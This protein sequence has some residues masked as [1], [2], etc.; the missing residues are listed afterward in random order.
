MSALMGPTLELVVTGRVGDPVL[1]FWVFVLLVVLALRRWR[2]PLRAPGAVVGVH[3]TPAAI[4][5]WC[6]QRKGIDSKLEVLV[7]GGVALHRVTVDA[8]Q[9]QR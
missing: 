7:R 2:L 3:A 4:R 9:H 5:A 8:G 6:P 1:G